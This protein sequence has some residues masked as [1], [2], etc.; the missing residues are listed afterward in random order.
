MGDVPIAFTTDGENIWVAN[1]RENTISKLSPDGEELARLSAG[2]IPYDFVTGGLGELPFGLEFDGSHIWI[3]NAGHGT[4]NKMNL[5]G[6]VE[7][8]YPVGAAPAD[9][10][11]DGESIWVTNTSDDTVSKLSFP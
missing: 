2:Q 11:F 6:V 3:A 1:W 8:T 10:V 9:L 4:V 5:D 7:A